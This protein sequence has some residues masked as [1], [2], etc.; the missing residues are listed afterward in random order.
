VTVAQV[1]ALLPVLV[2]SLVFASFTWVGVSRL[3]PKSNLVNHWK[4]A[5]SL[6]AILLSLA[7]VGSLWLSEVAGFNPC[8]LCWYQ[9]GFVYPAALLVSSLVLFAPKVLHRIKW[10]VV[11]WLTLSSLLSF[12]HYSLQ[13]G[14]FGLGGSFCDP[15]NPCSVMW[16]NRLGLT[17][18]GMAGVLAAT[19]A[20]LL[21]LYKFPDFKT[22]VED[23]TSDTVEHDT[24]SERQTLQS[25][26]E[27]EDV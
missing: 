19:S 21:A 6:A 26:T 25:N 17:I 13:R 22:E 10:Y 18:P 24:V 11:S 2:W 27:R 23:A 7:T 1:V 5:P 14:W 3:L 16:I 8:L 4:I 9:R 20:L 12:Y 15:N